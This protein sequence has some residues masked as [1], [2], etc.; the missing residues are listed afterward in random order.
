MII[1]FGVLDDH[2]FKLVPILNRHSIFREIVKPEVMV[3][4][5]GLLLNLRSFYI[6]TTL[7]VN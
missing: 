6:Q 7:Q 3:H 4:V 2:A 1:A 5:V